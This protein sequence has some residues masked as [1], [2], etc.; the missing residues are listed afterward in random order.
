MK[1]REM[2]GEYL[3][4]GVLGRREFCFYGEFGYFD[5]VWSGYMAR[6]Y[7]WSVVFVVKWVF[8][9]GFKWIYGSEL[10]LMH[11]GRCICD[12]LGI[13]FFF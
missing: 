6:N 12:M 10:C 9:G 5:V 13:F 4:T 8:H 2:G 1:R 11:L 7:I 3:C